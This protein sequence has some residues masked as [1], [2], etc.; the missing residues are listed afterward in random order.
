MQK[1]LNLRILMKSPK[2][3]PL[4]LPIS[5]IIT[6]RGW[7]KF[8]GPECHENNMLRSAI[9]TRKDK[10]Y[11]MRENNGGIE[12]KRPV[13]YRNRLQHPQKQCKKQYLTSGASFTSCLNKL[14]MQPP[15]P[16]LTENSTFDK[17]ATWH[18]RD[19]RLSW[20]SWN[21]KTSSTNS[22]FPVKIDKKIA[23]S[24]SIKEKKKKAQNPR[25]YLWVGK[26]LVFACM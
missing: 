1:T 9:F 8:S 15:T 25:V 24:I 6:I 16:Y 10:V 17:L 14:L 12:Q 2:I 22:E 7:S 19:L 5:S 21:V 13:N 23:R 26:L 20:S 18:A 4:H 3:E 11:F